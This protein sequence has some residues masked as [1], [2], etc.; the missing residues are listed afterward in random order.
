MDNNVPVTPFGNAL[1][2]VKQM[3]AVSSGIT[4]PPSVGGSINGLSGQPR[5]FKQVINPILAQYNDAPMYSF[6]TEH[7]A[8][9][10]AYG[11]E[12]F[13]ELGFN[14]LRD[15]ETFYNQNTS[16]WDDLRRASNYWMPGFK[17]GFMSSYHGFQ[18]MFEGDSLNAAALARMKGSKAEENASLAM[19]TRG[20]IG[21]TATNVFF[22]LNYTAGIAA[23]FFLEEAALLAL[24]PESGGA[25]LIPAVGRGFQNVYKAGK[26]IWNLTKNASTLNRVGKLRNIYNLRAATSAM[27]GSFV[28]GIAP[29]PTSIYS[30]VQAGRSLSQI[31][32]SSKTYLDFYRNVRLGALA[33]DESAME[34]A[35]TYNSIYD[36]LYRDFADQNGRLPTVDEQESMVAQAEKAAAADYFPNLAAIY[37]TNGITFGNMTS[38]RALAKSYNTILRNTAGKVI[39]KN[40]NGKVVASAIEKGLKANLAAAKELGW[41]RLAVKGFQKT[42]NYFANNWAEGAQELFQEGL[43]TGVED[44]YMR[45]YT[46]PSYVGF[47][48]GMASAKRGAASQWSQSG[49]EAFL[50]GFVGGGIIGGAGN[51]IKRATNKV[52]SQFTPEAYEKKLA[53]D[54]ADI[55]AMTEW[56]NEVGQDPMKLFA[57]ELENLREQASANESFSIADALQDG[58]AFEDIKDRA[59]FAHI[60]KLYLTG[61]IPAFRAAILDHKE[62]TPE[63][64]MELFNVK[65]AEEAD[66]MIDT[67]A[68]R[69]EQIEKNFEYAFD[70]FQNPTVMADYKRGTEEYKDA[71]VKHVAWNRAV[72]DYVFG[73][74]SFQRTSE[75]LGE[76][77]NAAKADPVVAGM[78]NAE[79]SVLF[80]YAGEESSS[81][82]AFDITLEKEIDQALEDADRMQ[83]TIQQL[84]EQ[85]DAAEN[86]DDAAR[87]RRQ[88]ESESKKL[89]ESKTKTELLMSYKN[90]LENYL[91]NNEGE[92]EGEIFTELREKLYDSISN[93]L[94]Y[95][96]KGKRQP[97]DQAKVK[98]LVEKIRDYYAVGKDNIRFRS[99]VSALSDPRNLDKLAAMHRNGIQKVL[100]FFMLNTEFVK[101][102][103]IN[104]KEKNRLI[105]ELQDIGV[106]M[107]PADLGAFIK[108][109]VLPATFYSEKD[110]DANGELVMESETGKKVKEILDNYEFVQ[111]EAKK[112]EEAAKAAEETTEEAGTTPTEE[113]PAEEAAPT[114]DEATVPKTA[115]ET[116]REEQKKKAEAKE[117]AKAK[118][119]AKTIEKEL[120]STY[121]EILELLAA[122]NVN[123]KAAGAEPLGVQSFINTDAT[124]QK[125]I[126]DGYKKKAK[127][128]KQGAS[129]A[130]AFEKKLKAAATLEEFDDIVEM[131]GVTLSSAEMSSVNISGLRNQLAQKL[132]ESVVDTSEIS[133]DSKKQMEDNLKEAEETITQDARIAAE[134]LE[135]D[136]VDTEDNIDNLM[137]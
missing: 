131:D 32:R 133:E 64:K 36:G 126:E 88:Q 71:V 87:L 26:S 124:A 66:Q 17:S 113:A 122:T 22:N 69:S 20:G 6:G 80:N 74:S 76:I 19:S 39:T 137:C 51:I 65:T 135:S 123:R 41:K 128:K 107:S 119:Q 73:M 70:K 98:D 61:S 79:F 132:G 97:L 118:Y 23:E 86:K 91:K 130:A 56:I 117:K 1:A 42:G 93:Y 53:E 45:N 46:D 10:Q 38:S 11:D 15:N 121:K 4:A 106:M 13:S 14:I 67:I 102:Q 103:L 49:L 29:F 35:G 110:S 92:K 104:Q 43:A 28:R 95:L 134:A 3:G 7:Y 24:A 90:A 25:S 112:S 101:Q 48:A 63:E 77:Y 40:V 60:R 68:S 50:G 78:S 5:A 59:T 96:S 72:E 33:I 111:E 105:T 12:T 94:D 125:L 62:L 89:A 75:R 54:A 16:T 18:S 81:T 83:R 58:K 31:A 30:Q 127:A 9:Q 2:K 37:L 108:D 115:E 84:G 21:Q 100:D 27:G 136:S 44:Y 114:R 47:A 109:G 85:A 99:A 82:A 8:R 52:Y 129:K 116:V 57:P 55:N 120:P 34:A